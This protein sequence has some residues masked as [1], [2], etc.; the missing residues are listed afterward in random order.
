VKLIIAEKP[1]LA[2]NIMQAIGSEKFTRQ[3][4]YY[5]SPDYIV[6]FAFGHL[7][8]LYDLEDYKGKAEQEK[9]PLWTLEDL[10]FKPQQ[11]KFNLRKNYKTNTVDSGVRAQF[12]TIKKL[13]ARK[14]VE[15]IINAGDSDREGEIIIRI[16]LKEAGNKKPV[17][18]LWM[19]DQTTET[20]LSGLRQLKS[21]TEYDS[22]ANE[23]YART[24]IDWIY[25]INLTRLATLKSG[26]MLRV[27][28]VIVPIVKAIYD[29]E[30]E[31]RNFIPR[32]Y[33]ALISKA[34][35][36][37]TPIELISK[38]KYDLT[39]L[40]FAQ[41]KC[42]S[43]NLAGATV[44]DIKKDET[45]IQAGKLYSLSNLQG[46][47]GKKY[48][49]SPKKSLAIV[50]ALYDAGYVSY[51]R[52]NSEYLATAERSKINAILD[53]LKAKGYK[54]ISKDAK[55]SIYDDSKIESHSAL[56]PTLKLADK[57]NLSEDE[58]KVYSTILNR[59]LAVFCSEDCL[60]NRTTITIAI[61]HGWENFTLRGDVFLSKGWM[62][63]DDPGRNDK[64]LPKLKK[65]DPVNIDFK[66]VEKE[67]TPPKYYTVDTL[68]KFLKNPFKKQHEA[69]SEDGS[70]STLQAENQPPLSDEQEYKAI[71][72]GVEIGTEASR[73]GIIDNAINSGYISLKNNTYRL[74][75]GGE[76]LIQSLQQL[77]I[78]MEKEKTAELGR[79]LKRVYR[80]EMSIEESVSIAFREVQSAFTSSFGI[81]IN[82][83]ET[84][85][86][87]ATLKVVGTCPKCGSDVV[88]RQKLYG[89]S[90]KD[91]KFGIWKNDKFFA[92]IGKKVTATVVRN[93]ISKK[94]VNLKG[95]TSARTGKKF[96]CRV[97]ADFSSTYPKYEI[98]FDQTPKK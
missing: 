92:G 49:M 2:K 34:E 3:S 22:L 6:T 52:T 91:C 40:P 48:K 67:T 33:Y 13:C 42:D 24:Y 1:S 30:M 98:H 23:G 12:S 60:V 35:T 77:G 47:L 46:V 53:K 57:A 8:S 17:M 86:A 20:I 43:Y 84:S 15:S 39:E 64:I 76:F 28:R 81:H 4:G 85:N 69:D 9:K 56:T 83:S 32:K 89:C 25:G 16:I 79:V 5:E 27:G 50:Q 29:R 88:E 41:S 65:G 59:F 74:L 93:L 51:P 96:D 72:E 10:P 87:Q 44:K 95:C 80:G 78:E 31:I 26:T 73:T 11:F 82:R 70:S 45:A 14:D 19:P 68:N 63:Y 21:D 61:N 36:N 97:T 66:P 58:W 54:V 38:E 18:R 94:Q 55:K 75:P 90:N 71:F 37:G 62:Q 7:F